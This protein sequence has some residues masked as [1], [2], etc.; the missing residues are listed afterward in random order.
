VRRQLPVHSPTTFRSLLHGWLGAVGAESRESVISLVKEHWSARHVVLTDSG[1]S[2]LILAIK[3]AVPSNGIVAIPAWGCYDVATAAE[4]ANV[5]VVL[6]DVDPATLAPESASF[7]RAIAVAHAVVI[8][9]FYGVPV[10]MNRLELKAGGTMVIEDAAQAIGAEW[11]GRPVGSNGQLGVLSFGRGKGLNG[12]GGGALLINSSGKQLDATRVDA[13]HAGWGELMRASAQW[14]LARPAFY[15]VPAAL[16]FLKLGET[17]YHQPQVPRALSRAS[18]RML[19][20]NWV[21]AH[22]A[23]E[24]RRRNAERLLAAARSGSWRTIDV[25]RQGAAGYLRL[26]LLSA[27]TLSAD[28]M[29]SGAQLG[30]MPG[31]PETLLFIESLRARCINSNE[32]FPGADELARALITLPTHE[33][34][35]EG[36]LQRIETW[37]STA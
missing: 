34:L 5:R 26:P 31:Y 4:G 7:A 8:V 33:L 24:V 18:A 11:R 2:A 23:T 36:D 21:E 6:Y 20:A 27:T 28:R 22:D 10:D 35:T 15:A 3:V 32:T 9:H 37:L 13:G 14:L 19:R 30:I 16:P 12:G 1:T 29:A 25:P 17:V